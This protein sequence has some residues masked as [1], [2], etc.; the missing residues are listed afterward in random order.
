M[1]LLGTRPPYITYYAGIVIAAAYGGMGPG[2]L[3]MFIGVVFGFLV[4]PAGPVVIAQEAAR[5]GLYILSGVGICLVAEGMHRQRRRVQEQAQDLARVVRMLDL[6]NVIVR[7]SSDRITRWNSGC[8][9]LYGYGAGEAIGRLCHDLLQTR[10]PEPLEAIRAKVM[11]EGSWH[12]E[13]IHTAA[14]GR[15]VVVSSEWVVHR[16]GDAGDFSILEVVSDITGRTRAEEALRQSEEHLRQTHELLEAVTAGTHE[17]VATVDNDLRFTYVNEAYRR[18][19]LEIFGS[20]PRLGESMVTALAHLPDEQRA[21]VNVWKRAL[22]GETVIETLAFGDPGRKRK[23]WDLRFAPILDGEGRIVGAGEIAHDATERV[24][25]EEAAKEERA[26]LAAVVETLDVGVMITDRDGTTS[27]MNPAGLRL[28][29]VASSKEIPRL[30]QFERLCEMRDLEDRFIPPE[31]RPAQRA[32]AGDHFD[33]LELQVRNL[34]SGREWI[35]SWSASPVREEHG[36][37][38]FLVFTVHDITDRKHAEAVLQREHKELELLVRERTEELRGK[39]LLL[40]QQSRQAAMGE[41]VNNIAHQW[42]QPLNSLGLLIQ[43]LAMMREISSKEE[44]EEMAAKAMKIIQHMS[45]TIDDFRDYFKPDKERVP[46]HPAEAV[47]RVL[48]LTEDNFKANNIPIEVI[49]KAD[50]VVVGYPNQFGQVLLN[51]LLNARDAIVERK[52]PSPKVSITIDTQDGRA[53]ITIA[54][55]AGGI[56]EDILNKI[57]EPYF[58]TKGPDKGTGIGLFMSKT[59][60]EK[61]MGGKLVAYNVEDGAVF[62]IEV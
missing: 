42:R 51:I 29:G 38:Q 30:Q 9:R 58:T 4:L 25:A 2:L 52:V 41:M 47:A 34:E 18:D 49:T 20:E 27:F 62:K 45:Q 50:A 26:K 44:L 8:R 1:P 36:E 22:H 12:G 5:L 15:E 48:K 10:F 7:D 31:E 21:A 40:E 16:E 61:N 37:V 17:H 54:D 59:I 3:V 46:F 56:P 14:D 11:A 32:V 23:F 57:F 43:S 6:A 24:L 33:H 60:I 53:V 13:L 19:F 55:N 28:L 39:E 35:G